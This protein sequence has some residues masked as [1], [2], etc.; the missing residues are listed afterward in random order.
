MV[1]PGGTRHLNLD[2]DPNEE[3]QNSTAEMKK[4]HVAFSE[5]DCKS[6]PR[7]WMAHKRT[8]GTEWD[9]SNRKSILEASFKTANESALD[10]TKYVETI[11]RIHTMLPVTMMYEETYREELCEP[12][13]VFYK[14]THIE[15][16]ALGMPLVTFSKLVLAFHLI[17]SSQFPYG[18][19]SYQISS[20]TFQFKLIH[21][22]SVH[23]LFCAKF[24]DIVMEEM[25]QLKYCVRIM[26]KSK[27]AMSIT[28]LQDTWD[29]VCRKVKSIQDR[30]FSGEYLTHAN[31]EE[32]TSPGEGCR[33]NDIGHSTASAHT[34]RCASII[35][36]PLTS[37][38]GTRDPRKRTV[39]FVD[40]NL[41][42]ISSFQD[43]L[44][45]PSKHVS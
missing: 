25:V 24:E 1:S 2:S 30:D 20:R 4:G 37:H 43:L 12:G 21:G 33:H 6:V 15:R 9:V 31:P 40:S 19:C 7:K 8:T 13:Q 41:D 34:P 29:K 5:H 22:N 18:V 44:P 11:A 38:M 16:C 27:P 42:T 26:K 35:N 32:Q 36:T 14:L 39:S 17:R 3:M 28:M 23:T 45:P 10:R